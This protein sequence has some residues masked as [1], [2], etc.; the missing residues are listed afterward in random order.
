MYRRIEVKDHVTIM[1][2]ALYDNLQD[3]IEESKEQVDNHEQQIATDE[4]GAH[5]FRYHNNV[6]QYYDTIEEEWLDVNLEKIVTNTAVLQSIGNDKTTLGVGLF[7]LEEETLDI[8]E[9]VQ[10]VLYPQL[11]VG[12]HTFIAD[13]DGSQ[14]F[15]LVSKTDEH[16]GA[17]L[18]FGYNQVL[19]QYRLVNG[20]WSAVDF[21]G[22][23]GSSESLDKTTV[24]NEDGSITE[25]TEFYTTT[26]VF[27][28]DGSIVET[29]K[30]TDGTEKIKTTTFNEDGSISEVFE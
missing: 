22:A 3:G 7:K 28:E 1:N 25:T 26:Y 30:Y 20:V 14:R 6:F 15:V 4:V 11:T 8:N 21:G 27:N 24:F 16:L 17:Y 5:N 23:G 29:T 9:Y 2:K 12:M 10:D 18:I 19:R 13:P